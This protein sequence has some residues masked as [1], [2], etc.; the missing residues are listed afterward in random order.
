MAEKGSPVSFLGNTKEE[1]GNCSSLLLELSQSYERTWDWSVRLYCVPSHWVL[2]STPPGRVT[3]LVPFYK[4]ENGSTER[5]NHQVCYLGKW[6]NGHGLNPGPKYEQILCSL[7]SSR[8]TSLGSKDVPSKFPLSQELF[9]SVLTAQ[10]TEDAQDTCDTQTL[11]LW[12]SFKSFWWSPTVL[13]VASQVVLTGWLWARSPWK[14][15]IQSMKGTDSSTEKVNSKEQ[16]LSD[17]TRGPIQ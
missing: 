1:G 4:W 7:C 3:G 2:K 6:V 14:E 16:T 8:E 13:V 9:V 17:V 5:L 15:H 11:E 12:D 10:G